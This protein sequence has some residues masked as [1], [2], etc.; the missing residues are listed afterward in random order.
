MHPLPSPLPEYRETERRA[1]ARLVLEAF[2]WAVGCSVFFFLVYGGT[3]WIASTRGALPTVRFAWECF[4]PLV[5]ATVVPYMSID[6]LFFG[7]FFLFRDAHALR[8]HARRILL[9][10]ALAG[11]CFLLFPLEM[12]AERPVVDGFWAIWFR[13]L[14]ALDRPHNLVPSLHCA[15]AAVLLAA[16]AGRT[17]DWLRTVVYAWFALIGASTLLTYQHHAIDVVTGLALG[18]VAL[19]TFP[20]PFTRAPRAKRWD[21]SA[22]FALAAVAL[23][24]CAVALGPVGWIF[25]WPAGSCAI[26]AAAY[27]GAGAGVFRKHDDGSMPLATRALLLPYLFVTRI[28]HVWHA[29]G[30]APSATIARDV[31]I[32]GRFA[33]ANDGA[34][35]DLAAE[36]RPVREAVSETYLNIPV[37]DGTCPTVGQLDDAVRFIARHVRRGPVHVRCALGLSRSATVAAAWLLH[38]GI[39]PDVPAAV[40]AVRVARPRAAINQRMIQSLC[41]F[42]GRTKATHQSRPFS[43]RGTRPRMRQ[44]S[45]SGSSD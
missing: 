44:P 14:H 30:A 19:G 15:L 3:N 1:L 26:M 39:A 38:A 9:V 4:I 25:F 45:T 36:C 32:G 2:A 10:I 13:P 27:G 43:S 29:R 34:L 42:H 12:S 24:T 18:L 40:A 23:G 33:H 17:R 21:V 6:L 5:P 37:L 35:L 41:T 20:D 7:S 22:R 16:Y 11:L 31:I 8:R 28:A